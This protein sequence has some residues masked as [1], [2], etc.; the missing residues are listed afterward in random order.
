[1]KAPAR[2]RVRCV[3]DTHVFLDKGWKS[4]LRCCLTSL[5]Q[6]NLSRSAGVL[7]SSGLITSGFTSFS[8][9]HRNP[10]R[11][12]SCFT[13]KHK[14]LPVTGHT[15]WS[16]TRPHPLTVNYMLR[17]TPR[18]HPLTV[19]YM[20]RHTPRPHP[21][22]VNYMLRHTPRPHPLTVNYMLRHTP[23]PHPLTVN[24]MLRHTPRPHPLTVNYMLRHTRMRSPLIALLSSYVTMFS[25]FDCSDDMCI[26]A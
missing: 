20:L 1:M 18:P 25:V 5:S 21:L 4:E 22:T 24:Y 10:C 26:R 13:H 7:C 16:S 2:S 12:T 17:H 15:S 8:A 6:W 3:Y 9:S 11:A 23:R 19:N 14:Q